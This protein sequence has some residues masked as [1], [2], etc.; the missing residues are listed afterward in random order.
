MSLY[1][2][3]SFNDLVEIIKKNQQKLL[4]R[5][6]SRTFNEK[7]YVDKEFRKHGHLINKD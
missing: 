3:F 6:G 2:V 1:S 5:H 7:E 4:E